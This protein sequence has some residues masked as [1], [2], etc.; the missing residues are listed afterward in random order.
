MKRK[1]FVIAVV[2]VLS[3][4]LLAACA[5]KATEDAGDAAAAEDTQAEDTSADTDADAGADAADDAEVKEAYTI[6]ISAWS[7]NNPMFLDVLAYTQPP[8]EA[9]G[10]TVV[11]TDSEWDGAK[12]IADV[13][14]MI[15]QGCDIIL[16]APVDSKGIKSAL[17]SC[18]EADIP[19]IIINVPAEDKELVTTTVATNHFESGFVLGEKMVELS[20]GVA[21]IAVLDFSVS[22]CVRDRTAGFEAAIADYPDM[23]IVCR[24]DCDPSVEAAIPVMENFLQAHPEITDVFNINDMQQLGSYQVCKA[25]DRTDIRLYGIDGTQDVMKLAL[26]GKLVGTSMQPCDLIGAKLVEVTYMVL[27]GEDVDS[28][29]EVP[30]FFVDQDNA[31]DYIVEE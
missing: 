13:E 9:D 2:V 10:H 20:G 17:L 19:V 28:L 3:L 27:A 25:A 8:L 31:A 6:G 22:E 15:S 24:Q 5:P 11:L 14:D 23:E 21:K 16:I 18:N 30:S 26:E 7:L 4:V 1:L 29:Y 12:Q